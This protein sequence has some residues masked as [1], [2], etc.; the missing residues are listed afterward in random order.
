VRPRWLSG[1][2]LFERVVGD[3]IICE[4]EETTYQ[5]L[6]AFYALADARFKASWRIVDGSYTPKDGEVMVLWERY[7]AGV[8]G[9]E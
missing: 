4:R 2:T 3:R 1:E 9:E 7:L 6:V 8:E 5:S